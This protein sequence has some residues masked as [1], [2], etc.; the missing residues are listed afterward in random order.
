[1]RAEIS[2]YIND[3]RYVDSLITSLVRQGYD[4][5]FNPDDKKV[6]FSVDESEIIY[7]NYK[8]VA[9]DENADI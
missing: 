4:V 3:E 7:F 8:R 6:C 5:Y 2:V 9:E 1:M